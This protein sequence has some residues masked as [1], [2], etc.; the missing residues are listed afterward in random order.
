MRSSHRSRCPQISSVRCGSSGHRHRIPRLQRKNLSDRARTRYVSSLRYRWSGRIAP[1]A[2]L[3]G[4]PRRSCSSLLRRLHGAVEKRRTKIPASNARQSLGFEGSVRAT[5]PLNW[6]GV[7]REAHVG[8]GV[9]QCGRTEG[10]ELPG[11][12]KAKVR[13]IAA[14][15]PAPDAAGEEG[16]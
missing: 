2:R 3:C 7:R 9:V 11:G 8:G 12:G 14:E 5:R 6:R 13:G 4:Y 10:L 16:G 15:R 1:H